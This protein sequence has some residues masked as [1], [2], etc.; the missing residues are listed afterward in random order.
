MMRTRSYTSRRELEEYHFGAVVTIAVPLGLLL[1]QAYLPKLI[2]QLLILDLPLIAVIFFAVARRSPIAGALTGAAIGLL[3]DALTGQPIGINGMA[4]S[5]IGFAASSIGVQ[6]D[7]EN[8]TTRLLMSFGFSLLQSALLFLIN[9]SLLG[10]GGYRLLWVHELTRAGVNTLVAIP[11]FAL[12][13]RAKKRD[14]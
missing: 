1:L 7:V 9:R 10:V 3:Q 4:K 8:L 6:V 5:V 11:L 2:P 13:D 14:E 12:L